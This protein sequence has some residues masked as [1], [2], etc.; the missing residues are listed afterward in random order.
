MRR[1]GFQ[2]LHRSVGISHFLIPS[3][4][5]ANL[6]RLFAKGN[7]DVTLSNVLRSNRNWYKM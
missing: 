5:K 7:E 3:V 6:P 2:Q 4:D 1:C